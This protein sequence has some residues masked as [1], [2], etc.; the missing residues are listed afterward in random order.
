MR[1]SVWLG[2]LVM[3][4]MKQLYAKAVLIWDVWGGC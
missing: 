1:G 4:V 2:H 3:V